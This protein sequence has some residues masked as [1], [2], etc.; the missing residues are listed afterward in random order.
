MGFNI[1]HKNVLIIKSQCYD[2]WGGAWG[3]V[4]LEYLN[5]YAILSNIVKKN[6]C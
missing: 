3:D 2:V 5:L 1:H 6:T 4:L